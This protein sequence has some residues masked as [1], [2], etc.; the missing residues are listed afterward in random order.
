MAQLGAREKP[1]MSKV[2]PI[3]NLPIFKMPKFAS[4]SLI[5]I[6]LDFETKNAQGEVINL[7]S[8]PQ[9]DRMTYIALMND[10]EDPRGVLGTS[11]FL[12]SKSIASLQELGI[13]SP[14]MNFLFEML[15]E[16]FSIPTALFTDSN[17]DYKEKD[18]L[19][20]TYPETSGNGLTESVNKLSTRLNIGRKPISQIT[21]SLLEKGY[22]RSSEQGLILTRY[23]PT[24][25]K[26]EGYVP[27]KKEL[28]ID[29]YGN[30][31]LSG[32]NDM[33]DDYNPK[34]DVDFEDIYT[35]NDFSGKF[36]D[37]EVF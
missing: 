24:K 37:S 35:K 26:K 10:F 34:K 3:L 31:V 11:Y 33:E 21:T 8:L 27:T 13:L 30:T 25:T 29:E 22:L 5:M 2:V 18:F 19:I 6:H 9:H 15:D 17:L 16:Q 28:E 1:K 36:W 12:L 20:I 7:L 4:N 32:Y 14:E 23:I